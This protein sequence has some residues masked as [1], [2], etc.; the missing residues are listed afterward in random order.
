[1]RVID[2]SVMPIITRSNTNAP[3]V[4]IG[5]KGADIIKKYWNLN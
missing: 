1:L 2:A 5:E 3:T 4:M